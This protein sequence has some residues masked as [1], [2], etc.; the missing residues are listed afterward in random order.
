M[1]VTIDILSIHVNE[2]MT[3][4][5]YLYSLRRR[6]LRWRHPGYCALHRSDQPLHMRS[7]RRIWLCSPR[8]PSRNGHP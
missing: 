3:R 6:W 7:H 2:R 1:Y 5:V 4:S 8:Y